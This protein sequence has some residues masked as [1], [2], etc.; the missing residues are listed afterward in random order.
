MSTNNE[1]KAKISN[2]ISKTFKILSISYSIMLVL[3][4]IIGLTIGSVIENSDGYKFTHIEWFGLELVHRGSGGY[5]GSY[6]FG[7]PWAPYLFALI[8][9][10]LFLIP[11][12]CYLMGNRKRKLTELL[13]SDLEIVGSYTAFIPVAKIAL[14]MPIEKIDNI[15]VVNSVL[16]LFTGKTIRI[17]SAS[18]II[19]IPYVLNADEVV[20]FISEAIEKARKEKVKPV[21]N[22]ESNHSDYAGNLQKLAELRDKGII[23]EEE[24][25]QKKSELLGKI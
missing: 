19:K 5:V 24:F 11:L 7:K 4:I 10:I 25:N 1:L 21:Q 2:K 3:L 20:A 23:T 12:L 17:S 13:V 14:R 6:D 18:G 16:F 9:L 22:N 8:V 15:S